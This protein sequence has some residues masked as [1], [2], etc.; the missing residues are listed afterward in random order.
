M[1][2]EEWKVKKRIHCTVLRKALHTSSTEAKKTSTKPER[3]MMMEREGA[4][5]YIAQYEENLYL[6]REESEDGK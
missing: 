6:A 4:K 2:S 1:E 3:K 5:E